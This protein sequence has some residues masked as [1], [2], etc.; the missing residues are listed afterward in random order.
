MPAFLATL[1]AM[2]TDCF[3]GFPEFISVLMFEEIAFFDPLFIR[4]IGQTPRLGVILLLLRWLGIFLAQETQNIYR[5]S[6]WR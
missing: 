3:C 2:A 4:G 5:I 6:Q 1:S